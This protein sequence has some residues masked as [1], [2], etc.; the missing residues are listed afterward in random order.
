VSDYLISKGVN[1]NNLE[2]T[3]F[4]ETNPVATNKTDTGRA[5]NR[6]VVIKIN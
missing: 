4:G 3:S 6:R 2:T 1:K 5:A